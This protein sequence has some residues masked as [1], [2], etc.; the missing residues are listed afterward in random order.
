DGLPLFKPPFST[1][2]A[3]DM[4]TGEHKW[5][6]PAGKGP[7]NHPAVKAA[8]LD[9]VGAVHQ[10]FITITDDIVFIAPNGAYDVLGLNTRG[11]ALIGQNKEKQDESALYAYD[12]KTGN[13]LGEIELPLGVF[14]A[15]MSYIVDGKQFVI[16]PVGGAGTPSELVAVQVN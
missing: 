11:N 2:T 9:T 13:L 7:I 1:I 10:S 8:G 15:L 12:A 5:R 14:G 6:V 16:A 3:I 4:N